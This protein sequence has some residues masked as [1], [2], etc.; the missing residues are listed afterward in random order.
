MFKIHITKLVAR[1]IVRGLV[2]S[3]QSSWNDHRK[4]KMNRDPNRDRV[5]AFEGGS[6]T[7]LYDGREKKFAIEER[8]STREVETLRN[9][10]GGEKPRPLDARAKVVTH[11]QQAIIEEATTP[12]T[13]S[14]PPKPRHVF[15]F[16]SSLYSTFL[17]K[18]FFHRSPPLWR[19]V[20]SPFP[21][22]E[23]PF[24]LSS[25]T[26]RLISGNEDLTANISLVEFSHSIY[27]FTFRN[28]AR[29]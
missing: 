26:D 8:Q 18:L 9:F 11:F 4:G 13:D 15:P 22:F 16:H 29:V 2:V 7:P 6:L 10:Y 23:F 27:E 3:L 28:R 1:S 25:E 17:V 14:N 21:N 5:S 19:D 20:V 24:C 12:S